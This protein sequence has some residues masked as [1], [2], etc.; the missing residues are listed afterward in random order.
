MPEKIDF[1]DGVLALAGRAQDEN[2]PDVADQLYAIAGLMHRDGTPVV[3]NTI[4]L[5]DPAHYGRTLAA[6]QMRWRG[7]FRA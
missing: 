2:L 1:R 4:R 7:V 3:Q 5:R 6:N